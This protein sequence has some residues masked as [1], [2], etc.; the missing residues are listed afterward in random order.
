MTASRYAVDM[1]LDNPNSCHSLLL[2]LVGGAKRVLD[3][4]C[5]EGL[6]AAVLRE[7]GCAVSGIELDPVAA[8][9]ARAHLDE[10]LVGDIAGMDL[11][12]TFGKAS[13]D[14]IVFADVLEHLPD[15]AA[16]LRAVR[17]LLAPGGVV[18]ISI[19]NVAHADLRISL[20]L[21]RW[22]YRATG[23]L[24]RTHLRFY[25]RET[26]LGLLSEG[27]FVACDVR[28]TTAE[29]LTTEVVLHPDEVPSALLELVRQDSDATTYQFVLAAAPDDADGRWRQLAAERDRLVEH[30]AAQERALAGLR[31]AA[32]AL[33]EEKASLRDRVAVAE[34]QA[35]DVEAQARQLEDE[36]RA[37]SA[38]REDQAHTI[39]DLEA[40]LAEVRQQLQSVL[41]STSWRAGAAL[42][43]AVRAL[44]T[45]RRPR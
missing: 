45:G 8:E 3:V 20:A 15:P 7:R 26:L 2:Q 42:R 19:P 13:F 6:F 22:D 5:D 21:G 24:D 43:A 17:P 23:L 41:Q 16:T 1:D 36:T 4:G 35:A 27:G 25:T 14:V 44:R 31:E 11:V 34:R 9:V 28:R 32:V 29:P 40:Q 33:N 10:L 37:R 18:V 38:T 39:R 30:A 12:G